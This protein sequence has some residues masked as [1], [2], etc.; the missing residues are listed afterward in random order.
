MAD[1]TI[2]FCSDEDLDYSRSRTKFTGGKGLALDEAY[3]LAH[4]PLVAPRHP[5]VIPSRPG[6][7]YAMGRHPRVHS[8]VIPVPDELLQQSTAYSELD[9]ELRSAPFAAKIA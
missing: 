7:F 4:Q 9:S 1:G 3:R 2:E 5:G 6:T 8:L